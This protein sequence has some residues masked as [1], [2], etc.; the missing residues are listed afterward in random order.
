MLYTDLYLRAFADGQCRA[1]MQGKEVV[2]HARDHGN[3]CRHVCWPN[4]GGRERGGKIPDI[5]ASGRVYC[6]IEDLA[7]VKA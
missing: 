1:S 4:E 2:L 5:D 3:K 7:V 6:K